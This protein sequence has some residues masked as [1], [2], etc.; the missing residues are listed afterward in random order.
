MIVATLPPALPELDPAWSR[1]VTAED[2]AGVPRTWH[3]L[4]NGVDPV[5]GTL[6]CVHGNPTWSF[7]WRRF[8]AQAAPG[9]RVVAVDQLGMGFSERT[10]EPRTLAQRVDDLGVLTAELGISGA[11]VTIGHDW[12]GPISLGWA[13]AHRDQLR[14]VVLTNTAVHQPGGAQA[15]WLIRV[16][17]TPLLRRTVCAA[18][19]LFV[20]ATSALSRPALPAAVRDALAA[21]YRSAARR[22]AVDDFVAD[23]PLDSRHRSRA[24]LDGI[25]TGLGELHDVPVLALWGPRDPVF[26]DRYLRDL[27][28]RLPHTQLHRYESASH[29]VTEDAP[30]TARHTWQWIDAL[31]SPV[32]DTPESA[33]PTSARPA[34]P[35]LWAALDE[36]AGDPAPAVAELSGRR[37]RTVSFGLLRR[38]VSELAAGLAAHGL[39]PGDRVAL[40]V[41]P[42]A[43]LTAA[44]YACW[45]A[46]AV[47]VVA[48]AGLGPRGLASALRAAGPDHVIGIPR[49][50]VLAKALGV[51]G[52]RIVAGPV[53][54]ALRRLLGATSG[55]ADLARLGRG[56]ELPPEP[57]ADAECAVVFTSGS[58]GPAKGVLYRHRQA[59]AQRDALRSA[60][61][62][63]AD[64]RLVAAFPPFALY[65]PA[66]GI[67]TSVPEE[68]VPGRLTARGLADAAAAVAATVVFASPAALR[69]VVACADELDAAAR[70]ALARVRLVVS[71]GAPVPA[72]LLHELRSVLP[73]AEAHTPYGMTEALPVTDITLNGIEAAG[74]GEGICVGRPLTGVEVRAEPA[75]A[76]RHRDRT[77]GRHRPDHR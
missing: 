20:R 68:Q 5:H 31:P 47:I 9:W 23:I 56:H 59:C 4:D 69:S 12:G 40:L 15:P 14:A 11:V 52:R 62:L 16:A 39:R 13:L 37:T 41:P 44:V 28:H 7:L 29:L 34:S 10:A 43:D 45:R 74:H 54:P 66:L 73:A 27:L 76:G 64:D 51:P 65:G 46:G 75:R 61:G 30:Q 8:L 32:A 1:L 2:A 72:T 58:T 55:L 33:R 17:R 6:L 21:P 77:A 25:A 22:G 26:S 38:R 70:A 48:D 18:T 67:A 50:L 19:P 35:P 42:G 3:V 63:T 71:A 53:T 60:F 49:G 36:R 57:G 24:T